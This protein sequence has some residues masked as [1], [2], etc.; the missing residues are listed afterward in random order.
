MS[1]WSWLPWCMSLYL[2]A[3]QLPISWT[4]WALTWR[5]T[6][7][8]LLRPCKVFF[9]W[10]GVQGWAGRSMAGPCSVPLTAQKKKKTTWL[11]HFCFCFFF[12]VSWL[13][14]PA[15]YP[16]DH[17]TY[18][19]PEYEQVRAKQGT[20][21]LLNGAGVEMFCIHGGRWEWRDLKRIRN[22][23]ADILRVRDCALGGRRCRQK[24]LQ[25]LA[26]A[27]W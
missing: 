15:S 19:C 1:L 3:L 14:P 5:W 8:Y 11:P 26:D 13:S 2:C 16:S 25:N 7:G 17:V 23:L 12:V 22:F 18:Q 20:R 6:Q 9:L 4:S 27:Y 21:D 10:G 24:K